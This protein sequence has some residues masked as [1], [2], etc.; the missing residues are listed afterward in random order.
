VN[1]SG[2][3][4]YF[5]NETV[6]FQQEEKRDLFYFQFQ[7]NHT[8]AT[9]FCKARNQS[10]L[11]I[12]TLTEF[13]AIKN[14][15]TLFGL[16]SFDHMKIPTSCTYFSNCSKFDRGVHDFIKKG[17]GKFKWTDRWCGD[18]CLQ[19]G[20]LRAFGCGGCWLDEQ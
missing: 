6:S 13:Q 8:A 16:L 12:E 15:L 2:V 3:N 9:D 10:L 4:Y 11:A 17:G 7:L 19:L 1:I 18:R 5:S 14:I 20:K